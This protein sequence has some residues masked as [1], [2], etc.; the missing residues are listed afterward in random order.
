MPGNYDPK[1][2]VKIEKKLNSFAGEK[3]SLK[4]IEKMLSE[5][6]KIATRKQYDFLNASINEKISDNNKIDVKISILKK[7]KFLC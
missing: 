3:Y 2:F 1:H 7:R 4:V 5:L 6:E